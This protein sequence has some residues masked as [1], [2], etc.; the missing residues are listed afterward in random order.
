MQA[1]TEI[2]AL[3]AALADAANNALGG[4]AC[5][6]SLLDDSGAWLRDVAASDAGKSAL[7]TVVKQYRMVDFPVTRSV[8][9]T[10]QSVQIAASDARA[11]EAEIRLLEELGFARVLMWRLDADDAPIGV[12]E[13]YRASDRPFHLE[14]IERGQ[15]L[16]AFAANAYSRLNLTTKL[17]ANYTETIEAL[18]SALEARDPLTQAHTGRIRDIAVALAVSMRLPSEQVRAIRLGAILHDVGKIGVADAILRKPGPL[19]SDEWDSMRC[20]P[21]IGERMLRNIE[22]LAPALPVIRHHHERWDGD[23]YPDRLSGQ[24]IPLGA[25]IVAV[26]DSLDAMTSDRPYRQAMHISAALAELASCAGSQFDPRCVVA[27]S[28]LVDQVGED[29]LGGN[30]DALEAGYVR[31]AV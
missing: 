14:E 5:M 23:G 18:V 31:Y 19:T 26:C 8:V 22:F 27:L 20:H 10:G 28:D 6:V 11:D 3:F 30:T 12:I 7:N 29:G 21:V 25:R 1:A 24:A 4:D 17:E 15:T 13:V 2:P 9:D 16:A